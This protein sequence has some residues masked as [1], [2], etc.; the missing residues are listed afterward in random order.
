MAWLLCEL[1]FL[2]PEIVL[3]STKQQIEAFLDEKARR[4]KRLVKADKLGLA[5]II[6]LGTWGG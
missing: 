4:L 1:R 2:G 5:G 6:A 3:S